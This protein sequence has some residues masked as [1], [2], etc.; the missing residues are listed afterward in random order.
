MGGCVQRQGRTTTLV[1]FLRGRRAGDFSAD[2][3]QQ[4]RQLIP[5]L[6]QASRLHR[7]LGEQQ[8]L[9][10]GAL[11]ALEQ[12]HEGVL[13]FARDGRLLHATLRAQHM[14]ATVPGLRLC[15]GRLDFIGGGVA[16]GTLQALLRDALASGNGHGVQP[17]GQVTL[18]TAGG[19]LH[20]QV[21]PLPPDSGGLAA[22]LRARYG[23]TGAEAQLTEAL[24][25]GMTLKE[26]AR[27]REV[28]FNTVRSQL[29]RASAKAGVRRQAELVRLA[30]LS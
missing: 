6:Q 26:F 15:A 14:L 17:G 21:T 28:S 20:C 7:R 23:M 25:K 12:L 16:L 30:L 27:Q 11:A 10:D 19:A 18:E 3:V 2:E 29:Q 4:L 1:S 24:A 13:L 8:Q 5:H 22:T 9:Q